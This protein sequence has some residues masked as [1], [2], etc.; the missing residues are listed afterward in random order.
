MYDY[1]IRIILIGD[2]AVGKTAFSKKLMNDTFSSKYD[3]TIGVDYS[4]KTI[5]LNNTD[6]IKCQ[7]WDTAGQESFA[8][9]IKTYYRDV[10]GVILMYDVNDRKTYTDLTFWLN[11]IE[12][13][14][15]EWIISKLLIANKIDSDNRVVSTEEGQQFA[16]ENGFSF[17]EIS[18]KKEFD[19]SF[20]LKDLVENIY[21]QKEENKGIKKSDFKKLALAETLDDKFDRDCCCC[22]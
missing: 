4:S 19:V 3:A 1:S 13:N 11:E 21:E 18:V 5:I 17:I 6:V 14:K 7:I 2:C 22:S 16:E 20:A 12:K 15:P 8:P 9:L 10:G